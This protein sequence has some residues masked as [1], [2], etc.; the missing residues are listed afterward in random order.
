MHEF[1]VIDT[2]IKELEEQQ[3]KLF[4]RYVELQKQM[5]ELDKEKKN[6]EHEWRY[7][8]Q[9][10]RYCEILE[11]LLNLDNTNYNVENSIRREVVKSLKNKFYNEPTKIYAKLKEAEEK[12]EYLKKEY[13]VIKVKMDSHTSLLNYLYPLRDSLNNII[14]NKED[15]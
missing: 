10:V 3:S 2:W 9:K 12:L 8:N 14:F 1:E 15:C 7:S 6:F 11:K 13:E 4:N 5:E